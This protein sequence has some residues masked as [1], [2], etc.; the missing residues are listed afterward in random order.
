MAA[1]STSGIRA[2]RAYVELGANDKLTAALD[3]AKKKLQDFGDAVRSA[4]SGVRDAGLRIAAFGAAVAG[5]AAASVV[6]YT[7]IAGDFADLAAQTGLSVEM[8]SELETALKDAGTTVEDFAKSAVKMQKA[9]F[10]AASGS[11]AAQASF[12]ALGLDVDRLLAMSPDQQFTAIAEALSK[13]QN[14]TERLGLAMEIFGKS[15]SKLMPVLAGGASGLQAFR[16]EAQRL[17]LSI[18]GETAEAA[19]QLG[20]QIE[21]LQDQTLRVAVA[22][23]EALAPA[24]REVVAALQGGIGAVVQWIKSNRESVVAAVGWAIAIGT[25]GAAIAGIGVAIVAAG[26]V[27]SGLGTIV[28]ALSAVLGFL[29]AAWATVAGAA[30]AA[31]AAMTG[32]VGIAIAAV[33]ALVAAVVYLADGF[34]TVGDFVGRV[35]DRMAV[36]ARG[37]VEDVKV[38]VGGIGDALAAGNIMLAAEILWQ[39]L[40][41]LWLRGT[42]LLKDIWTDFTYDLAGAFTVIEVTVREIFAAIVDSVVGTVLYVLQQVAELTGVGSEAASRMK[43]DYDRRVLEENAAREKELT[44]RIAALEEA[45]GAET[46]ANAA[47]LDAAREELERLRQRAAEAR[48]ASDEAKPPPLKPIPDEDLALKAPEIPPLE[49]EPVEIDQVKLAGEATRQAERSFRSAGTFSFAA[50]AG[51]VGPDERTQQRIANAAQATASHTRGILDA[52]RGGGLVWA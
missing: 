6:A 18:S 13:V 17:G 38:A 41:V 25:V 39:G 19:D 40:K 10:E 42:T 32:P 46:K 15:A 9:I 30:T 1:G 3:R 22:I 4:G 48:K 52:M 45:R 29:S 27:I 37:A 47:E 43:A 16:A 44:D 8:M 28:G 34:A 12:A 5:A 31:W 49:V 36:Q 24:A 2:G 35:F 11:E 50:A 7:K 20:T 21:I 51:L 14:P 23:G 26:A 33:V